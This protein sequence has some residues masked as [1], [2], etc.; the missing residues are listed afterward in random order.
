MVARRAAQRRGPRASH[1]PY[2]LTHDTGPATLH[3]ISQEIIS[4]PLPIPYCPSEEL[5]LRSF[6][7]RARPYYTPRF[8]TRNHLYANYY[9]SYIYLYSMI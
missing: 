6:F 1:F 3:I 2:E 7:P 5:C 4:L 8:T 9:Y